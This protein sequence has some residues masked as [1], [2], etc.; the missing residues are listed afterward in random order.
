MNYCAEENLEI[1]RI[2]AYAIDQITVAPSFIRE[3]VIPRSK[4]IF[5]GE[6]TVLSLRQQTA[7]PGSNRD[8][9]EAGPYF[10]N[11]LSWQTDDT[12]VETLEQIAQLENNEHHFIY[13][14]YGGSPR[15]IYNEDGFGQSF[16]QITGGEEESASISI[17]I[18]SRMPIFM[19]TED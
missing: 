14:L 10:T 6:P 8:E 9:D 4:I 19:I 17:T 16:A 1:V 11:S 15:L 13:H 2:E 7:R 12:S 18:Q 5:I 3:R